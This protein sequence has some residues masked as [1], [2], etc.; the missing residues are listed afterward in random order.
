MDGVRCIRQDVLLRG[1]IKVMPLANAFFGATFSVSVAYLLRQ[2]YA[3]DTWVYSLYCS[4]TS[5]V[6]MIVPLFAVPL[7]GR[8]PA[9]KL[10]FAATLSIAACILLIGIGAVCGLYGVIPVM[11]SVVLI[12][13]LDCMTI[14]AAIPM[15]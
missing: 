10:Y 9:N 2:S 12:T 6:S 1:F 5:A 11:A 3:V 4:V 13:A 8:F 14:A 15:R 7:V